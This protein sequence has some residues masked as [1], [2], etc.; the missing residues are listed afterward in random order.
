MHIVATSLLEFVHEQPL[1]NRV[2]F[3]TLHQSAARLASPLG[4]CDSVFTVGDSGRNVGFVAIRDHFRKHLEGSVVER[5]ALYRA[6]AL[7]S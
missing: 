5:V 6:S 3:Q 7:R 4:M 1:T 2:A